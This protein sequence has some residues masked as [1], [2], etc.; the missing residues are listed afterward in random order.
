MYWITETS[1]VVGK[2]EIHT[3]T[4]I[5]GLCYPEGEK[6]WREI[7]EIEESNVLEKKR[8]GTNKE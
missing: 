2:V 8:N 7:K 3:G 1:I 4:S 5:I 6:E